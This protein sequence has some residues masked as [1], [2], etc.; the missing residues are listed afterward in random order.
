MSDLLFVYG[1]L[2]KGNQNAM[3]KYLAENA[4]FI[5][6]GW[7]Q[8]RMYQVS[9]YPGVVASDNPSHRVH[10]EIYRL[11]DSQSMLK[12]LDE[13][14]E[15]GANHAQPTEYQRTKT[16]IQTLDGGILE[17]V[18][19]YLYHWPLQ[20]KALIETGDFITCVNDTEC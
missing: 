9:Y 19:I 1:T 4:E 18:W 5:T 15:C 14:E 7:F 3:A 11:K 17:P 10:G 20:E 13:Y 6:D 2:R 8:G 12:V 16:C